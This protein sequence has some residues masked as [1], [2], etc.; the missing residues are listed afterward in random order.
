MGTPGKGKVVQRPGLPCF[1]EGPRHSSS[2]CLSR[3]TTIDKTGI[4]RPVAA[5]NQALTA[6]GSLAP[7]NLAVGPEQNSLCRIVDIG[8]ES[9]GRFCSGNRPRDEPSDPGATRPNDFPADA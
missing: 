6:P 4:Q 5:R 7:Q 8:R 2:T 1:S 9:E 3:P